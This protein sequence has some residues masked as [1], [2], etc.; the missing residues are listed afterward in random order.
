MPSKQVNCIWCWM[1]LLSVVAHNSNIPQQQQQRY[2]GWLV[3][4]LVY[5]LQTQLQCWSLTQGHVLQCSVCG[6]HQS[7]IISC[8][9]TMISNILMIILVHQVISGP[10]IY[11]VDSEKGTAERVMLP[12]SSTGE[13][14][15]IQQSSNN[16]WN[17][18]HFNLSSF[19]SYMLLLMEF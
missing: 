2:D 4:E 16:V 1:S 5:Y 7:T 17:Q 6:C 10:T 18:Y 11:K 13:T 19:P 8:I 9:F 3:E 14:S 12:V 15:L